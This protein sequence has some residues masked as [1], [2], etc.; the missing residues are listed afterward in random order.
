MEETMEAMMVP[1]YENVARNQGPSA[2]PDPPDS[3]HT[4]R[5]TPV[6]PVIPPV[7][8]ARWPRQSRRMY[9]AV[10]SSFCGAVRVNLRMSA[11]RSAMN[12]SELSGVSFERKSVIGNSCS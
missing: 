10:M 7:P 9:I 1:R 2:D 11:I 12:A 3:P 5:T 4:E 8:G 6:R